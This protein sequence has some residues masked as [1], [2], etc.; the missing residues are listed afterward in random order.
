MT[1]SKESSKRRAG[2]PQ[3]EGSKGLFRWVCEVKVR[4][5]METINLYYHAG[6]GR[7]YRKFSIPR[8][9]AKP[10][11]AQITKFAT[12]RTTNEAE[13]KRFA[14]ALLKRGFENAL[15][16]LETAAHGKTIEEVFTDFTTARGVRS[17]TSAYSSRIKIFKA[18]LAEHFP[19]ISRWAELTS[20]ILQQYADHLAQN[21]L[22]PRSIEAYLKAIMQAQHIQERMGV[23]NLPKLTRPKMPAPK[24]IIHC[25]LM[26]DQARRLYECA[27]ELKGPL[28]N[29]ATL[30]IGVGIGN[31]LRISEINRLTR[32]DIDFERRC[33]TIRDSKTDSSE[34]I[35]P[36]SSMSE[37]ALKLHMTRSKVRYMD[38]NQPLLNYSRALLERAIL[39]ALAAAAEQH[40]DPDFLKVTPKESLRKTFSYILD[41]GEVPEKYQLALMGH[42]PRTIFGNHYSNPAISPRETLATQ[43]DKLARLRQKGI[44]VVDAHLGIFMEKGIRNIL[45]NG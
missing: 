45:R 17:S 33:I 8:D 6:S 29:H 19:A 38:P 32:A 4:D 5:C 13:A 26:P 35:V 44:D 22:Q 37:H 11:G 7:Y 36:M 40:K 9:P 12:M 41:A 23:E 21:G 42:R 3:V 27:Q 16:D 39:R 31:G 28:G 15:K 34:R 14:K 2:R 25:H 24:A 1:G 30:L 18:Y 43:A 20:A 10:D